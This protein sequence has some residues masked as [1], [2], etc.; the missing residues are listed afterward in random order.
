[1]IGIGLMSKYTM[2]AFL[3]S[4]LLLIILDPVIGAGWPAPALGGGAAGLRH[5]VAQ[6]LLELGP[7]LPHLP[8]HRRDHPGRPRRARLHP[9]QLG[10]FIG[11]QWLSFGPLL[12]VLLAWALLRSGA[13]RE[14]PPTAP[15]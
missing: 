13:L 3:P 7:R 8:P 1:V 5:P 15:C 12:G 6:P 10:E 9:G 2:A 11:A 4:A 14:H